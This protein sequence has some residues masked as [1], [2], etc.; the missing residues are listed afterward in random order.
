MSRYNTVEIMRTSLLPDNK[1]M[2]KSLQTKLHREIPT[3]DS[4]FFLITQMGDRLDLLALQY[5]GDSSL[6][7]Y[8]ALANDGLFSVNLEPNIS[9]RVP[10]DT[11]YVDSIF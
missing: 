2:V 1:K 6:W 11:A 10:G 7:W 3:R 4:D 9:I 8:I 5:Y